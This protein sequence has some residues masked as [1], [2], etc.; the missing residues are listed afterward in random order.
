MLF[1]GFDF[2]YTVARVRP[3]VSTD[4]GAEFLDY[5]DGAAT[6]TPLEDAVVAP[7]TGTESLTPG[8]DATLAQFSVTDTTSPKGFWQATDLV[9]IDG[10][11]YQIEGPVQ[12]WPS[13]SGD[14]SHAYLLVNRWEG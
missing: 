10:I 8:R 14:L 2:D 7:V 1:S 4:R 9:E 6:V 3:L 11:R 12:E 13:V 5:S